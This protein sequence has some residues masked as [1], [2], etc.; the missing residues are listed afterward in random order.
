MSTVEAAFSGLNLVQCAHES[1]PSGVRDEF[2]GQSIG[3]IVVTVVGDPVVGVGVSGDAAALPAARLFLSAFAPP[4]A[5]AWFNATFSEVTD[6]SLAREDKAFGDL[7]L[8]LGHDPNGG[9]GNF[10]IATN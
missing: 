9:A 1:L 4:E 8:V 3:K 2:C 5:L 6:G 10:V 7:K